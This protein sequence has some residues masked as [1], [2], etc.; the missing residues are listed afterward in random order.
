MFILITVGILFLTAAA[1]TLLQIFLPENRY[2]WLVG[3]G[4][5][6][7]AWVS[8]AMWLANMPVHFE[9]SIWQPA[10]LFLQSPALIADG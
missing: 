6:L 8:V 2:S 3:T 5:S 4:G 9:F 10:F 1:L 7:L